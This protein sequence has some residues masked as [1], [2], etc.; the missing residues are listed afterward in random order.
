MVDVATLQQ[1]AVAQGGTRGF[2]LLATADGRLLISQSHEVDVVEP[3]VPP[4]V[5]AVNPPA[6]AVTALPLAFIDVTFDQDMYAGPAGDSSSV[7]DPAN[8]ALVGQATGAATIQSVR[9]DPA[10]RTALLIV[11]GLTADQYTLT[12]GDSIVGANG[13]ALAAPYVTQFTAVG[14]LSQYVKLTFTTTRSDRQHRHGLVRRHD[15]EHQPVQPAGADLPDPRPGAGLHRHARG[16][17]GERQRELADQ[18]QRHG[19]RR[20]PAGAGA[21]HDRPDAHDR[22]P[23]RPGDLVHGAGHRHAPRGHRP[24]LRQRAGDRA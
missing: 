7:T 12:V 2:D 17:Y 3:V 23:R 8:Y 9:Y 4:G 21:E 1:V 6:G 20:R 13:L 5:A 22:R 10:T 16:G 18:P 24:G 19:A 15:R 14:D 11:S